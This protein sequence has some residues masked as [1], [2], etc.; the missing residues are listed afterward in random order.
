MKFFVISVSFIDINKFPMSKNH[1]VD[2]YF[3]L[4]LELELEFFSVKGIH[5]NV[6]K[7]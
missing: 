2:F 1:L 4:A 7:V 6:D 3:L 5:V